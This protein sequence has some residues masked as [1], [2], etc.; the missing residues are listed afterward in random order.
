MKKR[1]KRFGRSINIKEYRRVFNIFMEG[2]K[3]EPLYFGI[4]R[5]QCNEVSILLH[6][7]TTRTDPLPGLVYR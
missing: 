4:I 2:Q 1:K 6:T 3:T 5:Q 7:S